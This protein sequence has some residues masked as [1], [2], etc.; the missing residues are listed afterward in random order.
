MVITL[1]CHNTLHIKFC[2]SHL[3]FLPTTLYGDGRKDYNTCTP[4][5]YI[6]WCHICLSV[7][8]HIYM[9]TSNTICCSNVKTY[10]ESVKAMIHFSAVS[11][12]T[13]TYYLL[14]ALVSCSCYIV[15]LKMTPTF[16]QL[17]NLMLT[18]MVQA[19]QYGRDDAG[20]GPYTFPD[21]LSPPLGMH[22]QYTC[23]Y[24]YTLKGWVKTL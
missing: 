21:L 1:H 17:L 18:G 2:S 8:T 16:G 11:C 14:C 7:P 5:H 12:A 20:P 9:T 22:N 3:Q 24:I 13:Y 6:H 23:V 19:W 10:F 4:I 15:L